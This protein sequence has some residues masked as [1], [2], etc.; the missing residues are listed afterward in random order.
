MV[1]LDLDNLPQETSETHL[2]SL[3][4][5]TGTNNSELLV[6]IR[7]GIIVQAYI[8]TLRA[9]ADK[10]PIYSRYIERE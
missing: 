1:T 8:R 3:G 10:S 4:F 7:E 2:R 6:Q 9:S 5:Q